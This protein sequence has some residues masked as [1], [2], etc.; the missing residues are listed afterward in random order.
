MWGCLVWNEKEPGHIAEAFEFLKGCHAGER[1][2]FHCCRLLW[3]NW[4]KVWGPVVGMRKTFPVRIKTI[5][6][7]TAGCEFPIT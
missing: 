5:E 2:F 7:G 4:D 6:Q 3:N 1:D